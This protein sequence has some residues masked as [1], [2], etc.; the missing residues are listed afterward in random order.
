V[1][2]AGVA[3][4][5]F[6][7]VAC[8][9]LDTLDQAADAGAPWDDAEP[10]RLTGPDGGLEAHAQVLATLS[11]RPVLAARGSLAA[12][13]ACI[14]A[15]AVLAE[16]PPEAVAEHWNLLGDAV[17]PEGD[18]DRITRRLSNAEER[19]RQRRA[20]LDGG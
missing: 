14:Q 10:L 12:T 6:D 3:R 16:A 5:A 13:G 17:E 1:T 11:D 19:G 15:A 2:A 9:A 8:S 20:L 18:P 7:G 4:A